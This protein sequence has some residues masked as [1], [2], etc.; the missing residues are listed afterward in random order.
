MDM[1][2][3]MRRSETVE[4]SL[5]NGHMVYGRFLGVSGKNFVLCDPDGAVVFVP[6]GED[7]LSYVKV[8]S[9]D[10]EISRALDR[11]YGSRP[12][13]QP[14]EPNRPL[15]GGQQLDQ[16]EA[17]ARR[18]DPPRERVELPSGR[19]DVPPVILSGPP[20]SR[21]A[22]IEAVKEKYRGNSFP[23]SARPAFRPRIAT[24]GEE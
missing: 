16:E 21:Q 14:V 6:S 19:V 22:A 15:D 18:V 1:I 23:S 10:P 20:S 12:S 7:N 13:H 11:L 5:K 2:E 24:E 8:V 4:I 9:A 3:T 17:P